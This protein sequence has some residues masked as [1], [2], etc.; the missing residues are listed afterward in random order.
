M[1]RIEIAGYNIRRMSNGQLWLPH[2]SRHIYNGL[3]AAGCTPIDRTH[4]LPPP[5]LLVQEKLS[6]SKDKGPAKAP[7]PAKEIPR[8]KR[9]WVNSQHKSRNP[10][11][12]LGHKVLDMSPRRFVPVAEHPLRLG[13]RHDIGGLPMVIQSSS[14]ALLAHGK[15]FGHL[16]TQQ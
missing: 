8:T 5:G 6:L 13:V 10:K 2:Y 4:L 11:R 16:D 15:L 1:D 14:M 12:D 3:V 9:P 7:A